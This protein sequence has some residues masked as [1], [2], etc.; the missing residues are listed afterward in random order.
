VTL[1]TLVKSA[2]YL[3][4]LVKSA[5]YL[6]TLATLVTLVKSVGRHRPSIF[7]VK[8]PNAKNATFATAMT[9]TTANKSVNPNLGSKPR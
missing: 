2:T 5:T 4:T 9:P 7:F 6:A 3:V 1:V 8:T